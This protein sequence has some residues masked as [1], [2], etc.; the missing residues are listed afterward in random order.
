MSKNQD[1]SKKKKKKEEAGT[2]GLKT[3]LK[4]N[5]LIRW[6]FHLEIQNEWINK[7]L[8]LARDKFMPQMRLMKSLLQDN[9]TEIYSTRMK[10]NLLLLRNLL[11]P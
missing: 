5:S 11:E 2:L 6:Y 1:L 4:Q 9:D 10:E 7:K 8:L 3:F